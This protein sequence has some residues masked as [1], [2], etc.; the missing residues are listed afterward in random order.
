MKVFILRP[1]YRFRSFCP[2]SA[3]NSLVLMTYP[4]ERRL[5]HWS[6]P[7]IKVVDERHD[8]GDFWILNAS[9]IIFNDH[10][11]DV[12][13]P[14]LEQ[15]G[16]LLPLPYKGQAFWF[17]NLLQY[18]DCVDV[19][20]TQWTGPR[21]NIRKGGPWPPYS[22]NRVESESGPRWET[23]GKMPSIP[24]G[25]VAYLP[26]RF[27]AGSLFKP[28]ECPVMPVRVLERTG[29]PTTE[30]K[31]AVEHHGLKGIR[32]KLEWEGST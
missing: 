31:A 29:D 1:D 4:P 16:E 14:I 25:P 28:P 23:V 17:L 15:S 32:F 24:R 18:W 20:R 3:G 19:E 10:V 13:Q 9:A 21:E 26:E 7:E 12:L 8:V 6:P 22:C 30:F 11:K 2:T 5:E 27:G